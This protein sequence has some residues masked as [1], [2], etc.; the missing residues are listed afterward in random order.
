MK[1]QSDGMPWFVIKAQDA[2]AIAAI[3]AY[4][5]LCLNA[6]LTA[7]AAEVDKAIAE[8]EQWQ[9]RPGNRVRLPE[10]RHLPAS[11]RGR[12]P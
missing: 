8:F 7:Q 9:Q 3:T 6:G 5:D 4:R 2:L 10:H 1:R 11:P 12:R